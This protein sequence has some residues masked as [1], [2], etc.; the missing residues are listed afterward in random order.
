MLNLQELL[1]GVV[2]ISLTLGEVESVDLTARTCTVTRDSAPTLYD[3]QLQ[4][5][6]NQ[7]NGFCVIPEV[8]SKI[9]V[10]ILENLQNNC[11]VVAVHQIQKIELDGQDNGGIVKVQPL[12]AELQRLET[13]MNILKTATL[14]VA[15]ALDAVIP[16]TSAAFNTATSAMTATDVSGLPNAKITH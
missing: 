5:I 11:F 13:N 10:G 1:K 16:G 2:P 9:V 8:G 7:N 6:V 14:A 4:P 12:S 3:V 15:T